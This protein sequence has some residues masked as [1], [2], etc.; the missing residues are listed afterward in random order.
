MLALLL[1]LV[2]RLTSR[3]F[4]IL[5]QFLPHFLEIL[6]RN[7]YFS[8]KSHLSGQWLCSEGTSTSNQSC[9]LDTDRWVDT[10]TDVRGAPGT[11]FNVGIQYSVTTPLSSPPSRRRTTMA[12]AAVS[13]GH[14]RRRPSDFAPS[15]VGIHPI[16]ALDASDRDESARRCRNKAAPPRVRAGGAADPRGRCRPR[17]SPGSISRP[18]EHHPPWT[19]NMAIG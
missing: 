12:D 5:G 3:N 15:A 19:N 8:H 14:G 9:A 18:V 7:R 1:A 6:R 4:T 11:R 13:R 16:R 17:C 2:A 10:K